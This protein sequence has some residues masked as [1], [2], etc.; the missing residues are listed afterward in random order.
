MSPPTTRSTATSPSQLAPVKSASEQP[1]GSLI[2]GLLSGY[3]VACVCLCFYLL[4]HPLVEASNSSPAVQIAPLKQLPDFASINDVRQKKS[5]FF[6]Y[7]RPA[8]QQQ[9]QAIKRQRQMLLRLQTRIQSGGQLQQRQQQ[10]IELL[11]KRYRLAPAHKSASTRIKLLLER[12][13]EIPESMVL[14]QAAIESA[15]GTSRFARQANNLF[16]QWCFS[17]GCGLVPRQRSAGASHEV[18]KYKSIDQAVA[19]YFLNINSHPAYQ[20]VRDIR[21]R[22]REAQQPLRGYDMVSGLKH[23]SA[24]G[25]AYVDILRA[26]IRG[27]RLE[28]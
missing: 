18:A 27:N 12:I 26:M 28:A 9:N 16:G 6:D 21:R 8:I 17:R 2:A 10:Q 14:A 1:N 4:S 25:L 7:L 19:A 15:W 23:Y 3:I 22:A 11:S 20:Q 5:A 13:D 24:K